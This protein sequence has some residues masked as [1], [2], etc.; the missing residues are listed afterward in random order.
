MRII[1]NFLSRSWIFKIEYNTILNAHKNFGFMQFLLYFSGQLSAELIT[2]KALV[3]CLCRER[4]LLDCKLF[5]T[6]VRP[7]KGKHHVQL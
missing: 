5:G 2:P 6:F 4:L 1:S 7:V 3:A